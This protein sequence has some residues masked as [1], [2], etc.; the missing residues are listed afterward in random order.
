MKQIYVFI[1][2]FLCHNAAFA[3]EI[4]I[5]DNIVN[6]NK[7]PYCG[8]FSEGSALSLYNYTIKN[9]GNTKD[10]IYA[11]PEVVSLSASPTGD[12]YVYYTVVFLTPEKRVVE[13]PYKFG[14]KNSFLKMLYNTKIVQ[15][16]SLNTAAIDNFAL[17]Y[18]CKCTEESKTLLAQRANTVR[19]NTVDNVINMAGRAVDDVVDAANG[20]R[21]NTVERNRTKTVEIFGNKIKQDFK[22]IGYFTESFEG[23]YHIYSIYTPNGTLVAKLTKEPFQEQCQYVT[24]KDNKQHNFSTQTKLPSQIVSELATELSTLFYM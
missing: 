16:D 21:N 1:A 24:P 2:L 19:I 3:Q 12:D 4:D 15:N 9:T 17:K 20:Q 11:K 8:Y 6:V 18:G 7:V 13:L 22:E 10:L 23:K 5:N 14:F